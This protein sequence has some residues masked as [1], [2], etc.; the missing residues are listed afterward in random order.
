MNF[1]IVKFDF[2]IRYSVIND[3]TYFLCPWTFL[4]CFLLIQS[5]RKFGIQSFLLDLC[6]LGLIKTGIGFVRLE[7]TLWIPASRLSG[8]VIDIEAFGWLSIHIDYN[9]KYFR[10][11][12]HILYCVN[13]GKFWDLRLSILMNEWDVDNYKYIT[14]IW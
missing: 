13:L 4:S 10:F 1:T 12:C 8:I 9:W 11:S 5:L 14:F 7:H 3:I 2:I 6:I